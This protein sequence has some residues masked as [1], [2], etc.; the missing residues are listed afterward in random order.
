MNNK[1]RILAIVTPA[2]LC[3][4]CSTS[5]GGMTWEERWGDPAPT[6]AAGQTIVIKPD[7][8][9]VNVTGGNIVKFVDGDKSFAWNFDGPYGYTF[10]LNRVAP[11]GVLD[12]RVMAYVDP[13][14]YMNGR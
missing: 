4:A 2:L 11:P 7:T 6:A 1:I 9:Y 5:S 8:Q 12:H 3:A 14:P 10:E 13:D